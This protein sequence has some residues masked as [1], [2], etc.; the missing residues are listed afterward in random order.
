MNKKI[1]IVMAALIVIGISGAIVYQSTFADNNNPSSKP[2]ETPT[3]EPLTPLTVYYAVNSWDIYNK[4]SYTTV[5]LNITFTGE[6]SITLYSEN[7]GFKS[8]GQA[9]KINWIWSGELWNNNFTIRSG[10]QIQ[11]YADILATVKSSECELVYNSDEYNVSFVWTNPPPDQPDLSLYD[12]TIAYK[13]YRINMDSN[14]TQTVNGT[15]TEFY[16]MVPAVRIELYYRDVARNVS[17]KPSDI[18]LIYNGK[19][20]SD[21][22]AGGVLPD[23]I[24]CLPQDFPDGIKYDD[25]FDKLFYSL[26]LPYE[27]F[28]SYYASN[29][30]FQLIYAGSDLKINWVQLT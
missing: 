2:T 12:L 17:F 8:N 11:F 20:I 1:V 6:E 29:P 27:S 9:L 16:A 26:N 13:I 3:S 4:S 30:N 18:H 7:L 21:L 14:T 10:Q 24:R 22:K 23:R 19:E 25:S 5:N 28:E 15:I